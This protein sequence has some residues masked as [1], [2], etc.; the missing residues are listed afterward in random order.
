M[1][2]NESTLCTALV[3][4]R[5]DGQEKERVPVLVRRT[6]H[7]VVGVRGLRF[8]ARKKGGVNQGQF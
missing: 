7:V 3:G 4:E 1:I 6:Q 8:T 2:P 5:R